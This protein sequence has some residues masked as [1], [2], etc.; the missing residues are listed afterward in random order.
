MLKAKTCHVEK[1]EGNYRSRG[2]CNKHYRRYLKHG[3]VHTVRKPRSPETKK[4]CSMAGCLTNMVAL[5]FCRM[6]YTRFRK[7][8]DASITKRGPKGSGSLTM[9]YRRFRVEGKEI[10]EH[11]LVMGKHI[12][13]PL[14]R[15]ELV[16]HKNGVRHDNRLENLELCINRQPPGRRVSDTIEW[17]IEFL[18]EYAPEK[19]NPQNQ[20]P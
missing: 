20:A 16:H 15:N 2:M 13:R 10:L 17:C 19:L 8:G 6:H 12:G 4:K 9:G 11:R 7:H 18:S 5:G 1:C 14:K 3:N